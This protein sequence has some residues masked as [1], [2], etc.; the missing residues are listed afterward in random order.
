MKSLEEDIQIDTVNRRKCFRVLLSV[1]VCI[2]KK[3]LCEDK[4]SNSCECMISK[5]I[6][7][8]EG[9]MQLMF[10]GELNVGDIIEI[11]TRNCLTM[12]KCLKCEKYYNMRSKVELEPVSARVK[13]IK[14]SHCGVEFLNLN[15]RSFNAI[16][17]LVWNKHLDEIKKDKS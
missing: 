5:T 8:S 12:S 10:K 9:G 3:T 4:D 16:S 14:G 1:K 17:R 7:I 15:G 6:D 2:F 13:W 11:R